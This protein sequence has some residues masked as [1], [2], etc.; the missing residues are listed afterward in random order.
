MKLLALKKTRSTRRKYCTYRLRGQSAREE[1]VI[2]LANRYD[3]LHNG[4]D[5]EEEEEVVEQQPSL[6]SLINTTG[7][8][9]EDVE[10][11]CRKAPTAL[12]IL[13][14]IWRSKFIFLW[15]KI[16]I[17]NSNAKSVLLYHGSETWKLTKKIVSQ[18][19]TF[20]NGRLRRIVGV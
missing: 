6:G 10:A 8:T 9:E 7:G 19:Q 1:F 15:R 14:P 2:A 13:R 5:D 11:R 17:F 20:I 18:L 4:S 3:A 12:S 16:K